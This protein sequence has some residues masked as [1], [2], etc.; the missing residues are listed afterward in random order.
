MGSPTVLGP[1]LTA[2]ASATGQLTGP[3]LRLVGGM[4]ERLARLDRRQSALQAAVVLIRR[5]DPALALTALARRLSAA[6]LRFERYGRLA[7]NGWRDRDLEICCAALLAAGGP[8]GW[9]RLY[10]E[11]K[12]MPYR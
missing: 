1:Q 9:R 5:R 10:D 2:L 7:P 3:Q 8:V 11:L 6:L 12:K 4:L